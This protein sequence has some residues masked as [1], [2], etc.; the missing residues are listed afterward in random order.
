MA[1]TAFSTSNALTKKLWDEKLYRDAEKESYFKKFMGKSKDSAVYVKEELTKSRGD[2]ITFGLRMRLTGAG[3]TGNTTLEGN[4][5]RLTTHSDSVV[6]ER[7]RHAV[8]DDG[9]LTRQRAMFSIDEESQDALKTWM[10]EKIDEL[11]F[12]AAQTAFTRYVYRN[13]GASGAFAVT[14]T[15]NTAKSAVNASY[16]ITPDFLVELKTYAKT[17]GNRSFIPI[18]PIPVQG[19]KY[20]VLLVHDDILADLL[21]DD[22][23]QA[24]QK[25]AYERSNDH[26]IFKDSVAIFRGV[27]VHAHEN[28]HIGTDGGGG[29][30]VAWGKGILLGAQGLCWAWGQRPKVV[31]KEF[32]YDEEHGFATS[33]T[34]KVKKPTFD[35]EDYGTLGVYL[36]R[37]QISDL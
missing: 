31:K 37:T 35:S 3:V 16:K 2:E 33:I 13:G 6:L 9:E 24:A 22:D 12:D 26:P 32:D 27:V 14:T 18:R 28:M 25:E 36:P 29:S 11:C 1:K 8:R 4:E 10:T 5:E 34:A 7:Y 20:F 19:K 21:K 15:E 17:G 30:N 23:F